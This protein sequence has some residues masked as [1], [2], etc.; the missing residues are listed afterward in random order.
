MPARPRLAL[1]ALLLASAASA[2][3]PAAA[4]PAGAAEPPI[5]FRGRPLPR[6]RAFWLT[7]M[8]FQR[9]IAG[10]GE[11]STRDLHGHLGWELGGMV[12]LDSTRA[13]GGTVMVGTGES[14]AR[15]AVKGRARRWFDPSGGTLDISAGAVR[16]V[17][18]PGERRSAAPGYGLTGDVALGWGDLGAVT[19]GA[20]LVRSRGELAGAAYA[21]VRLG[22][23]PALAASAATVV[24]VGLAIA[25]LGGSY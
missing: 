9:R 12:N 17:V 25:A 16:V 21:G 2:A 15:V 24:I 4:Q 19:L 18:S 23:W 7:E 13:V 3:S 10:S 20:D 5:C 8:S 1:P 6:C 14:G 11:G 22:S